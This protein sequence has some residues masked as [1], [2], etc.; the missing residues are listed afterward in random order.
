M[1]TVPPAA[2]PLPTKELFDKYVPQRASTRWA[3][4]YLVA[5]SGM[6]LAWS[7]SPDW[8]FNFP[9]ELFKSGGSGLT[10]SSG[11]APIFGPVIEMVFYYYF[12]LLNNECLTLGRLLAGRLATLKDGRLLLNP[13]FLISMKRPVESSITWLVMLGAL[14]LSIM[15]LGD[16]LNLTYET[17]HSVWGLLIPHRLDGIN[18]TH[19]GHAVGTMVYG[20]WQ[21]WLYVVFLLFKIVVVILVLLDTYDYCLLLAGE[22]GLPSHLAVWLRDRKSN[23]AKHQAKRKA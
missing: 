5:T 4:F 1:S 3:A 12:F 17:V 11:F 19:R 16:F 22:E 15:I 2:E 8:A 10:I 14:V 20:F 21:P 9:F 13:P 7:R 6:I 23:P 18:P